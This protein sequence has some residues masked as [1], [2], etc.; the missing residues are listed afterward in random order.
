MIDLLIRGSEVDIAI[1]DGVISAIGPQLQ[2]AKN[3]IDARGLAILPGLIDV[4]VHFNEPGR[5]DWEGS[6]TG[7]RAFAAAGG[8]LFFDMPLNSSPCTLTKGDFAEKC[9]ALERSSTTNFG[10]WGGIVPGNR[11]HLPELGACG[12]VGFK[13]FLCDSGLPEF[14]RAD[15]LTL[16]E[17][18]LEAARMGLPVA[19]HA[20]SEEITKALSSRLI[21]AGRTDIPAFLQSRPLLAEVEAIERASL[22]AH[23]AK[24]K[25]HVVHI[26][27]G[28][29]VAAALEARSRGTDISIETCPH[30]LFFTEEDL[31]KVGAILKCTPPL[32][33]ANERDT[34]RDFLQRGLVDIIGS[35]HS[36]CPPA[37]KEK[38]SFF[39]IWGGIA[40]IQSTLSV[41]LQRGLPL[42]DIARL[43]AANPAK[44]FGIADRGALQVGN[45][46]D[47]VLLDTAASYTLQPD[48]LLQRHRLSPYLGHRFQGVV[49]QTYR[50]GE[51][52]FSNG[53]IVTESRGKLVTPSHAKPGIHA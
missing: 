46:A 52:I 21:A 3:E 12:A 40:G 45:R 42:S 8:T 27:S 31:L 51:L 37:M 53:K 10:L 14:P 43:T 6:E 20:E 28:R 22:L 26:S 24:C 29:G 2:S 38:D 41:L 49:R 4:H 19:V 5:A 48:A 30:Y 34:L 39:A 44:R 25:L 18:M 36:P 47:L 1:E 7:S 13:A 50:D 17:G 15:D 35:D 16:Y 9:R 11:P 32:R 23:E 33:G